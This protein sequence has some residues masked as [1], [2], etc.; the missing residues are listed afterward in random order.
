VASEP[1]KTYL[2]SAEIEARESELPFASAPSVATLILYVVPRVLSRRKISIESFVSPATK[3]VE[4]D[5][6]ITYLASGVMPAETDSPSPKTSPEETDIDSTEIICALETLGANT[7]I[8]IRA[9]NEDF[10][11]IFIINKL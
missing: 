3:L 4:R 1:N 5:A 10:L 9:K 11:N 8:A 6:K 7:K 2:P